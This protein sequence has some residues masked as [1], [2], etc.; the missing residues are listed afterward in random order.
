MGVRP[1]RNGLQRADATADVRVM[2]SPRVLYLAILRGEPITAALLGTLV[3]GVGAWVTPMAIE[4]L[5]PPEPP[6][7]EVTVE[8]ETPD[9]H[10]EIVE[11]LRQVLETSYAFIGAR[12][13]DDR[14]PASI[15]LW[16]SDEHHRGALGPGEVLLLT[17]SSLLGTITAA[18]I[19]GYEEDDARV[20]PRDVIAGDALV[21]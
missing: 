12:N 3:I 13:A 16:G 10:R 18:Y 21:R 1:W 14:G 7:G 11:G 9:A 2:I 17:H 5:E 15:T 20:D 6:V 8:G 19:E 4:A